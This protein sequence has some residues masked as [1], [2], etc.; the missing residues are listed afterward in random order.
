MAYDLYRPL[1]KP[2]I[3]DQELVKLTKRGVVFS[4]VLGF[5]LAFMFDRLM[6]LWVFTASALTATVFVPIMIG[7]Y[8]KG[9]KTPLAGILSCGIGLVSVIIYYITVLNFGERNDT[10][11][12]YIWSFDLG[13]VSVSLWQEYGLVFSLPMSFA[14]FLIGNWVGRETAR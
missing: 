10:Y 14:G 13:G 8:W 12:T 4:W 3:S 6:A 1:V 7:L 9:R 11:G 2:D 5:M